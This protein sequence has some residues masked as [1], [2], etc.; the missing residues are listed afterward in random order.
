MR[1]RGVIPYKTASEP[2][3]SEEHAHLC[4]APGYW[5]SIS[6]QE[7]ATLQRG[8][9]LP[10]DQR[11][12]GPYPVVGSNG[13]VGYHKDFMVQ[14]PGVLVGRS[15]S[16]GK[17]T[18]VGNNYW[19]LNTTLWVKDFHGNNPKFVFFLL[20]YLDLGKYTGGVSVPTLNRNTIHPLI[21]KIPPLPE[22][23]A[24]AHVLQSVQNAIQARHQEIALE[25]ERKAALMQH[26][27]THGI[28]K[29]TISPKKTKF[30]HVPPSWSI[31]PL[32]RCAVIQTGLAKGR[33][34]KDRDTITLPY[35]RVA[36]VQDGYLDLSEIKT[37]EL[38]RSEAEHYKL[39]PGDVV[40]TEG[41]DFD[42][43]G[44]GFVWDGQIAECVHQN[45]VFAV[46]ANKDV[47]VPAYLAYLIQSHYG[48]AYFL[49]VAHKTTNL[50]C[51]NSTKLKAFPALLPSLDEQNIIATTLQICDS[52]ITALEKEISLYEELFQA[53]LEDLMTGRL[54][55]VPLLEK[56][57][58]NERTV[59][60]TDT[61]DSVRHSGRME[62]HQA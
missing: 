2:T 26:L 44:R 11:K 56:E 1:K 59:S 49:S 18:W 43:L 34:L 52:K 23:R 45:H 57:I 36:N 24:I 13:I 10:V 19:P 60:R 55:T 53:L 38:Y 15:G 25:R 33:K 21:I 14:G 48:K 46:R 17:V 12:Q 47:L 58:Y 5:K 51:I 30:G 32:E 16:V 29:N 7:V 28:G 37:I 27:F 4:G 61:D 42:K 22:Q 35:L 8:Y 39:H 6:L 31:Q 54:S 20:S 3:L 41:G 40:V 9:D 50:A 62:L